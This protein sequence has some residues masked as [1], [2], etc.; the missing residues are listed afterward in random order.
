MKLPILV[1]LALSPAFS[2]I[3]TDF[4]AT[5]CRPDSATPKIIVYVPAE[6]II[7]GEKTVTNI[8]MCVSLRD[9]FRVDLTAPNGPALE[10]V[11]LPT[12]TV[13]TEVVPLDPKTPAQ[14]ETLDL[15]LKKIPAPG[16][17]LIA[18]LFSSVGDVVRIITPTGPDPRA[19]KITLPLH[20]P[21]SE[22][23]RVTLIYWAYAD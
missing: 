17:P 8:P 11:K 20:R 18:L 14:Q 12:T 21:F 13:E 2:Q 19:V 1:L 15:R 3:Q 9:D 4:R 22:T 23:D 7:G 5:T 10:V 6:V 16:W